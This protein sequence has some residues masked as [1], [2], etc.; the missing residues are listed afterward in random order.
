MSSISLQTLAAMS[1]LVD[2]SFS[3][4]LSLWSAKHV[5]PEIVEN[6]M[7]LSYVRNL[8]QGSK[9][10]YRMNLFFVGPPSCGRS[11]LIKNLV[12]IPVVSKRR[13][14]SKSLAGTLRGVKGDY[15]NTNTLRLRGDS[16]AGTLR[17][18]PDSLLST[19]NLL[20]PGRISDSL[21]NT[22]FH[23]KFLLLA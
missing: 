9:S 8:V 18:K 17:G 21:V 15:S 22:K 16:V 10:L 7:L 3:S 11:S 20:S 4:D 19:S 12:S 1:G 14:T 23:R 6:N 2:I 5:P 13:M